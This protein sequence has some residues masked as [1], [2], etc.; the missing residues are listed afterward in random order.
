M[1]CASVSRMMLFPYVRHMQL[2]QRV[3]EDAQRVVTRGRRGLLRCLLAAHAIFARSEVL[4]L[5][6]RLYVGDMCVW[7]QQAPDAH[8]AEFLARASACLG[9]FAA[10]PY[11]AV[12]QW[13]LRRIEQEVK[14]ETAS[15]DE[16]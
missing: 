11:L 14:V 13:D 2:A 4:Y 8:V 5:H 7:I 16:T 6:N 3:L 9:H 15:Q 10:D 1:V 12:P